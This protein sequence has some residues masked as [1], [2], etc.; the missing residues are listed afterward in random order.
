MCRD[1]ALFVCKNGAQQHNCFLELWNILSCILVWIPPLFKIYTWNRSVYVIVLS[2]CLQ[3]SCNKFRMWWLLCYLIFWSSTLRGGKN[4]GNCIKISVHFML[5]KIIS[6]PKCLWL[7]FLSPSLCSLFAYPPSHRCIHEIRLCF[8]F[9]QS[10]F[11]FVS[12]LPW[13]APAS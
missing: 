8:L 11:K 2:F 4:Q 12:S 13:P 10:L 7:P 9:E 6:F 3:V 1:I 5:G